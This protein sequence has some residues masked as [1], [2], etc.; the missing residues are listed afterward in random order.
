M[1]E[2]PF[3]NGQQYRFHVKGQDTSI[4]ATDTFNVHVIKSSDTSLYQI[5]LAE[6]DNNKN[7]IRFKNVGTGHYLE[8][9]IEDIIKADSDK[10]G[11]FQNTRAKT[12]K[13]GYALELLVGD[14][15]RP[16]VVRFQGADEWLKVV[17]VRSTVFTIEHYIP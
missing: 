13:E 6:V 17:E 9:N 8:K 10:H 5:W 11:K 4:A 12:Y 3:E 15:W 1:S 2:Y 14:V 7:E 16:I